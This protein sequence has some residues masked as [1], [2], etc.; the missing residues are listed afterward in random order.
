M[1]LHVIPASFVRVIVNDFAA[2]PSC[3]SG[4]NRDTGDSKTKHSLIPFSG[5]N[6]KI[7]KE[8]E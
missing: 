2:M 7:K 3:R 8:E 5:E 4:F 6:Q 1:V